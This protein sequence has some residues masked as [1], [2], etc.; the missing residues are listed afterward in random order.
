[1]LLISDLSPIKSDTTSIERRLSGYAE[2]TDVLLGADFLKSHHVYIAP[3]AGKIYF[4]YNGGGVFSPPKDNSIA[5][6]EN[7]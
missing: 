2:N 1:M 3:K 5:V 4:T 6:P 7:E